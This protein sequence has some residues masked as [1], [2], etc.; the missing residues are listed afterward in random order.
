MPL[1]P[2][3]KEE[4]YT[5]LQIPITNMIRKIERQAVSRDSHRLIEVTAQCLHGVLND[6]RIK[7]DLP[8]VEAD[9]DDSVYGKENGDPGK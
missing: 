8:F 4:I 3:E 1:T 2:A 5:D 9:V 7:L 6:L